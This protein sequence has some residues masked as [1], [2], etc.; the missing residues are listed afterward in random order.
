MTKLSKPMGRSIKEWIGR[1]ADSKPPPNVRLRIFDRD[2]GVCYL[3]GR[4][5]EPGEPWD[6]DHVIRLEDGGEN[7]ESNMRPALRDKHREKTAR[8]NSEGARVTA[9]RAS[10][11]G[12][13]TA[14]ARALQSAPM[15]TTER[16]A[17]RRARE[18][19]ASLPPKPMFTEVSK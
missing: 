10:H 7:R 9:K 17:K 4:K 2:G 8:E 19:K 12:L 1:T 6:A 11:V 18:P 15:P 5:I 16:A 14:P 3:S 13:R